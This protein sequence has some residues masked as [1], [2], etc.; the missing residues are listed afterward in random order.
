MARLQR[1]SVGTVLLLAAAWCPANAQTPENNYYFRAQERQRKGDYA[2]ALADFD[3]AIALTPNDA[4][5]YGKRADARRAEGRFREALADY[6]RA[7]ALNPGI[8]TFFADRGKAK[9]EQGDLAGALADYDRAL[10]ME[11]GDLNCLVDRA[12]TR[13]A[14]GDH[15]GAVADLTK[16]IGSNP[17]YVEAFYQR[18]IAK[19]AGGDPDGAIADFNQAILLDSSRPEYYRHNA[20]A[21]EAKG[22]FQGA[23][24]DLDYIVTLRK[25][26]DAIDHSNA[27]APA[28]MGVSDFYWRGEARRA[29]GDLD[30]ALADFERALMSDPNYEAA[31]MGRCKARKEKGD[32]AGATADFDRA[33][34]LNASFPD[35]FADRLG[36]KGLTRDLDDTIAI[37]DRPLARKSEA[38]LLFLRGEARLAKG[39]LDSARSDLGRAAVLANEAIEGG[40][41]TKAWRRAEPK[42]ASSTDFI[43]GTDAAQTEL[44]KNNGVKTDTDANSGNL[45]RLWKKEKTVRSVGLDLVSGN[46][47]APANQPEAPPEVQSEAPG[48]VANPEYD[49]LFNAAGRDDLNVVRGLLAAKP[50]AL[51]W[52]DE[53]NR[54]ALHVAAAAGATSVVE[55]LLGLHANMNSRDKAGLTPILAAAAKGRAE[56]V[57]LFVSRGA[58]INDRGGQSNTLLDLAEAAKDE[59]TITMLRQR[60]AFH[61]LDLI[62]LTEAVEAGDVATA[63]RL[64]DAAPSLV[65]ANRDFLRGTPLHTAAAHG[66]QTVVALF[67]ERNADVNAVDP[68]GQTPTTVADSH[69]H[70]EVATYLRAHGG[71]ATADLFEAIQVENVEVVQRILT[72]APR[73]AAGARDDMHYSPLQIAAMHGSLQIVQLLVGAQAEVNEPDS[74]N[75]TPIDLAAP[76]GEKDDG[77]WERRKRIIAFLREHGGKTGAELGLP[78]IEPVDW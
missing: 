59:R 18:G 63:T 21:K 43:R 35:V 17:N 32:L 33:I 23:K 54:T 73:M 57:E 3:R 13:L 5:A 50:E 11:P 45:A 10:T 20:R 29:Q 30:G 39:E 51:T 67:L 12:K 24:R 19:Q 36:G 64:L 47:P 4:L 77:T 41:F 46:V 27:I 68:Q 75:R 60:Q 16:V 62:A 37:L 65:G 55:Y 78:R 53:K 7:I 48:L 72:A 52:K 6:D 42:P 34:A 69:H 1:C 28:A 40:F 31:L 76:G 61:S 25:R 44:T 38:R 74:Y 9:Q 58:D 15:A 26:R 49:R 71:I 14:Q 70:A 66:H 2:G 8:E 56:A 22:D